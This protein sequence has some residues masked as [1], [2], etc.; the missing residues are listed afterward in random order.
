MFKKFVRWCLRR[1]LWDECGSHRLCADCPYGM[2]G[3]GCVLLN[4]MERM[5]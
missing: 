5:H 3:A 1:L 4:A 2:E